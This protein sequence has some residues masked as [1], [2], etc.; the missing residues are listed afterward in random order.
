MP[1]FSE[2][3][4][5]LEETGAHLEYLVSNVQW[6]ASVLVTLPIHPRMEFSH[7]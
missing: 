2:G 4:R 7:T 1:L 3:E 6:N 5:L